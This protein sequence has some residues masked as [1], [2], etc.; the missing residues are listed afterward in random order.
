MFNI[1]IDKIKQSILHMTLPLH[2]TFYNITTPTKS[3]RLKDSEKRF[4]MAMIT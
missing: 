1:Y 2:K 3:F 4:T